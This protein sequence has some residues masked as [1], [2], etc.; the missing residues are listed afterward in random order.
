MQTNVV[1]GK[2]I[3]R[4]CSCDS[5]SGVW[6]VSISDRDEAGRNGGERVGAEDL[7]ETV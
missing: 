1:V 2:G 3:V 6:R 7:G 4:M 5:R